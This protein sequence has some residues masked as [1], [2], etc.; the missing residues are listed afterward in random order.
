MS[1][2]SGFA[3]AGNGRFVVVHQPRV[4]LRGLEGNAHRRGRGQRVG[5][6]RSQRQRRGH[7]LRRAARGLRLG[8]RTGAR[9]GRPEH[10]D[11]LHELRPLGDLGRGSGRQRRHRERLAGLQLAVGSPTSLRGSGRCCSKTYIAGVSGGAPVPAVRERQQCHRRDRHQPGEPARRRSSRVC[12]SPSWA[13]VVRRRSRPRSSSPRSI[14]ASRARI[15]STAAG[16]S[17]SR[18]RS[19]SDRRVARHMM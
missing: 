15:R 13:T 19:A 4:Q 8:G 14:S 6:P 3:K 1:L 2:G 10:A 16:A 17:T 7:V 11:L 9:H 5:G 12:S 18:R